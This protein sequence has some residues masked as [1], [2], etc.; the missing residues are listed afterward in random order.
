MVRDVL[1]YDVM[2]FG[3]LYELTYLAP[4]ATR[5]ILGALFFGLDLSL[6]KQHR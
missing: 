3:I 2:I 1:D 5:P 4:T 6:A